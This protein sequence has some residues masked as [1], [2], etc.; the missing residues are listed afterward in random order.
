MFIFLRFLH[1]GYALGRNDS[2]LKVQHGFR[3][4]SRTRSVRNATP[5][6]CSS[7]VQRSKQDK[8]R[9]H[10][11]RGA[12][13]CLPQH[14]PKRF[15]KK[16]FGE[17][18]APPQ[19][20]RQPRLARLPVN[21]ACAD[22]VTPRKAERDTVLRSLYEAARRLFRQASLFQWRTIS[23]STA[24]SVSLSYRYAAL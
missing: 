19:Q 16:I 18:E 2:I 20:S 15:C 21:T 3:D 1:A 10:L 22:D 4:T 9:E 14:S 6:P 7:R 17:E 24:S 11:R 23:V 12:Q 13:L 5:Y 8:E